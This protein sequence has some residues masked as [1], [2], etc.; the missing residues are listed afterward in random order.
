MCG[1]YN[2]IPATGFYKWRKRNHHKPPYN[3]RVKDR[4]LFAFAGLWEHWQYPEGKTQRIHITLPEHLLA[5]F[6]EAARQI[7]KTTAA[8]WCEWPS[9]L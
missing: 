2:F 7:K 1:R 8:I 6:D 4:E 9:R 3:I 5:L